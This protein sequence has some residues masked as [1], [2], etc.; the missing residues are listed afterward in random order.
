MRKCTNSCPMTSQ[1]YASALRIRSTPVE[2]HDVASLSHPSGKNTRALGRFWPISTDPWYQ[3]V[4]TASNTEKARHSSAFVVG[5][6]CA[7]TLIEGIFGVS[8]C[9]PLK[10]R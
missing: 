9:G 3:Y 8:V 5:S 7:V 6:G 10:I 4:H 1:S 2:K